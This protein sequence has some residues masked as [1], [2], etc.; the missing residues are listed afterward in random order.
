MKKLLSV[1]IA[2]S[3]VLSSFCFVV[4]ER[5]VLADD[6]DF[7]YC[8]NGSNLTEEQKN[9]CRLYKQSIE[10][11]KKANDEYLAQLNAEMASLKASI[12]EQGRKIQ[13]INAQISETEVRIS[14]IERNIKVIEDSIVAIEAEIEIRVRHIDEL[15]EQIK[16]TMVINQYFVSSKQ[17]IAFI[18]GAT[19]FVD[20]F[21]RLGAIGEFTRHD[22]DKIK[23]LN[24]EKEKLKEEEDLL[25]SQKDTL[26]QEKTGKEAYLSSLAVLKANAQELIDEYRRQSNILT[27][28]IDELKVDNTDLL[29]KIAQIEKS[30]DDYSPSYGFIRP[31]NHFWVSGGSFYYNPSNPNSGVHLGV[32]LATTRGTNVMA[33]AN[34]YI[35]RVQSGCALN[36]WLGNSCGGGFGNYLCYLIEINGTVYEIIC[37]HLQTVNVK[38]GDMVHQGQVIATEGTSGS[39]TG[40]HLHIEVV[41]LGTE[42]IK[43]YITRYANQWAITYG[44]S[45][46]RSNACSIKGYAPCFENGLEIFG[47]KY[48]ASY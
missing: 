30:L 34:G 15:N 17:Y 19:S 45:R 11:A 12:T 10:D 21:R 48:N 27:S 38:V 20:L 33:V 32:D 29:N 42:D 24:E 1:I 46:N 25:Q 35:V 26:Q 6:D 36:G 39:S 41:R 43:T 7:S 40:P 2:A 9:A 37:A 18:M 44:V 23:V 8:F 14:Q 13:E 31:M 16:E 3:I 47:L 4:Q 28:K 22:T 5:T